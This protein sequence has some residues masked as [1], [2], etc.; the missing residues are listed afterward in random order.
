MLSFEGSALVDANDEWAAVSGLDI[1]ESAGDGWLSVIHPD[2]RGDL[3]ACINHIDPDTPQSR[4]PV[5]VR[6]GAGDQ[7]EEWFRAHVRM[8]QTNGVP[9]ALMTLTAVGPHR[10]NE[11]RLVHV[12]THDGLTGLANR[13]RF[14]GQVWRALADPTA[15]SALLFIDLDHFKVVND[16]L[17]HRYGDLVLQAV[18][19]RI[20]STIRSTDVAGRLGGDE[21]GVFCPRIGE[22]NE[23]I[24]LAER[25][26]VALAAPFSVGEEIVIIDASIGV[27]F[28]T[29]TVRTVEALIDD[30][31]KAMYVAKAAGGGRWATYSADLGSRPVVMV[32]DDPLFGA[33]RADVDRAEE[34]TISAWKLSTTN[35]DF[36][37]SA[38]FSSIREALRRTSLLLRAS[39]NVNL[40][41][42]TVVSAPDPRADQ[43]QAAHDGGV[44]IAQ[45]TGMIA[46]RSG[47]DT[48]D[49]AALLH[50]YA[51]END[52][53]IAT[54]AKMLV[55]R[56]IDIDTVAVRSRRANDHDQRSTRLGDRSPEPSATT[57]RLAPLRAVYAEHSA[58]VSDAPDSSALMPRPW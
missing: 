39:P 54:A 27:A 23:V 56:V 36:E 32:G 13:T 35:R 17:G 6:V 28:T 4:T 29:D 3:C 18:C 24:A 43:L 57:E 58:A 8:F 15:T 52:L 55:E 25:V 42:T 12:S 21:I 40:A 50:D 10:S 2:D 9:S 11:A 41:T 38:H 44:A 31:D 48:A 47:A 19:K 45:A 14:V 5:S 34:H 1:G 20:E 46:Q 49:S 30:A 37:R 16:H 26:G 51:T 7:P 33:I 53:A 22:R